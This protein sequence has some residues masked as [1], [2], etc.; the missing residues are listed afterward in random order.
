MRTHALTG[1][2]KTAL[3]G[4]QGDSSCLLVRIRR[5]SSLCKP[6]EIAENVEL[7][8]DGVQVQDSGFVSVNLFDPSNADNGKYLS[9]ILYGSSAFENGNYIQAAKSDADYFSQF[10]Y[11]V[12]LAT[13]P[14]DA[15]IMASTTS[16]H[17][18]RIQFSSSLSLPSKLHGSAVCCLSRIS[19]A[20]LL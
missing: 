5:G 10:Q 19:L 17:Y 2:V 12:Q 6:W 20:E 4:A 13:P 9:R 7:N 16:N 3:N 11:L 15:R 8:E 18:P 1:K 14:A